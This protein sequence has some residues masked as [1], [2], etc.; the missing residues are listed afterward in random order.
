MY[1]ETVLF[2]VSWMSPLRIGTESGLGCSNWDPQEKILEGKANEINPVVDISKSTCKAPSHTP[3]HSLIPTFFGRLTHTPCY[4]LRH[5]L[6]NFF[7]FFLLCPLNLGSIIQLDVLGKKTSSVCCVAWF[8]WTES[9]YWE[10]HLQLLSSIL[11]KMSFFSVL[12]AVA[13]SSSNYLLLLFGGRNPQVPAVSAH[14]F[15][16]SDRNFNISQFCNTFYQG[17]K[18]FCKQ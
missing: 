15:I 14:A 7:F 8:H 16:N 10:A 2:K 13:Q 11:A 5:S 1:P 6:N 4:S 3:K 17:A 9:C 12:P 18:I